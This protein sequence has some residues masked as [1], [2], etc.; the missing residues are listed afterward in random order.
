MLRSIGVLAATGVA[1]LLAIKLIGFLLFP[2]L[3]MFLGLVMWALKIALIVGLIWFGWYL[4][5]RWT[6][7]ERGAEA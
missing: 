2:L 1:G 7:G 4:F 3:G 5:Q 6:H